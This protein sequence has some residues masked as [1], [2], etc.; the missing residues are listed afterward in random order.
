[1]PKASK[2]SKHAAET[3]SALAWLRSQAGVPSGLQCNKAEDLQDGS[4]LL[5]LARLV[6]RPGKKQALWPAGSLRREERLAAVV[7]MILRDSRG[8]QGEVLCPRTL[9][10]MLTSGRS[11]SE[12]NDKELT[13]ILLY[14]RFISGQGAPPKGAE[15]L[16]APVNR[17][18]EPSLTF[19]TQPTRVAVRSWSPPS[20]IRAVKQVVDAA[21][22]DA[23]RSSRPRNAGERQSWARGDD[24]DEKLA[25]VRATRA[26]TTAAAPPPPP[27]P[28]SCPPPQDRH[29]ANWREIDAWMRGND[30]EMHECDDVKQG[31]VRTLSDGAGLCRLV[32]S[33]ERVRVCV[34]VSVSV[35]LCVCVCVCVSV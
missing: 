27:R 15:L 12:F 26:T 24:V 28:R 20:R 1:M 13:W 5:E 18:R 22:Q 14:L 2:A 11:I 17:G 35:C 33:L 19:T 7:R 16:R 32:S 23:M 6:L 4:A 3:E 30:V 29:E 21:D 8:L 31:I 25:D 9:Q 34:S 10:T